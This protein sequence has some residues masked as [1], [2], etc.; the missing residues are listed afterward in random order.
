MR[1]A[2]V[3]ISGPYTVPDPEENV[4]QAMASFVRL[5]DAGYTP[6]CPHLAHFVDKTHPRAYGYWLDYDFDL[7][8]LCGVLL[9]MPGLSPG[10]EREIQEAKRLHIPVWWGTA[11]S[12]I[13]A[14]P[15]CDNL[16]HAEDMIKVA[17]R[18]G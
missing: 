18:A 8:A 14:G 7:L 10:A 4:S 9:R 6:I 15:W 5:R 13:K 16:V 12:F 11:E 1:L 17:A 3:F 2:T